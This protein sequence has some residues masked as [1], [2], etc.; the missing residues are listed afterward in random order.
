MA[1]SLDERLTHLAFKNGAEK[2]NRTSDLRVTNAL[3][4]QL[5]YFGTVGQCTRAPFQIE[6]TSGFKA[7]PRHR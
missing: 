7:S 1:R 5:S 4:Y 2:R 6:S 3:L